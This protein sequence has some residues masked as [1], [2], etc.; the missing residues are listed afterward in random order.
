MDV[1]E[2]LKKEAPDIPIELIDSF[3]W[4]KQKIALAD[5]SIDSQMWAGHL[6]SKLHQTRLLAILKALDS[7]VK[8]P[9]IILMH[10]NYWLVDGYT[11]VRAYL[12]KGMK[13][14]EVLVGL[15]PDKESF[16]G[17]NELKIEKLKIVRHNGR[18]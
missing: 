13:E 16:Y 7:G 4:S 12:Q 6:Q 9:P 1:K 11:R 14:V 17:K 18:H 10:H 5:I 3:R 8:L 15:N 2:I